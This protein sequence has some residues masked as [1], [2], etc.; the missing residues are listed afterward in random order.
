MRHIGA[1]VVNGFAVCNVFRYGIQWEIPTVVARGIQ[2]N[3]SVIISNGSVVSIATI[4]PL[5]E[6]SLTIRSHTFVNPHIRC[7]L[8]SDQIAPPMVTELMRIKSFIGGCSINCK[9]GIGYVCSVFH[10]S[11]GERH[12]CESNFIEGIVSV[13]RFECTKR[14]VQMHKTILHV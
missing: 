11:S 14:I 4:Q 1:F 8:A 5:C 12:G 2:Q 10:S 7:C 9:Q 6:N 3:I 13:F